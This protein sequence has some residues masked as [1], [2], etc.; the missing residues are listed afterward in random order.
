[1]QRGSEA[2]RLLEERVGS[3]YGVDLV[4][5]DH[6]PPTSNAV[7]F[8]KRLREHPLARLRAV[9]VIGEFAGCPPLKE[10]FAGCWGILSKGGASRA[11][12]GLRT[13]SARH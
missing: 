13:W 5:K 2:L 4:L 3:G 10:G 8:L 11:C 6:E 1:M 7:R 9:P 12:P